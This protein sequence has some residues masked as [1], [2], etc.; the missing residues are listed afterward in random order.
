MAA[1]TSSQSGDWDAVATWGGGGY[2]ASGDTATI[3]NTHTVT[4]TGDETVGDQPGSSSNVLTCVAGGHLVVNASCSLTVRGQAYFG[5]ASNVTFGAGSSLHFDTTS[6]VLYESQ[7]GI[8]NDTGKIVFNGTSANPCTI[9]N[10]GDGTAGI[11][12]HA[13]GTTLYGFEATYTNITDM[14]SATY[15]IRYRHGLFS[16]SYCIFDGCAAVVQ[17]G[18]TTAS[19]NFSI[20]NCTFKNGVGTYD[21]DIT[22]TTAITGGNVRNVTENSFLGDIR[23]IDARNYSFSG[24]YFGGEITHAPITYQPDLWE[25]DFCYV[26]GSYTPA[27]AVA[28]IKDT[29]RYNPVGDN[30]HFLGLNTGANQVVDGA[31]FYGCTYV[32]NE[33]DGPLIGANPAAVRTYAL[34]NI[35]VLPSFDGT[36]ASC[37]LF[38]DNNNWASDTNAI[39]QVEHC[40]V[41]T[42]GR[43]GA[44]VAVHNGDD[45]AQAGQIAYIKNCIFWTVSGASDDAAVSDDYPVSSPPDDLITYCGNNIRSDNTDVVYDVQANA[46]AGTPGDGDFVVNPRFIDYN[47]NLATWASE[48]LGESGTDDELRTAAVAALEAR[49]DSGDPNYHAGVTIASL[50]NWIRH[51]F[52]PQTHV[53]MH[54]GDGNTYIGA[55]QPTVVEAVRGSSNC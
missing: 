31:I 19:A 45:R 24:N 5:G 28:T 18:S 34:H 37:T 35:L 29:F 27:L 51:G 7:M 12:L 49:N 22:C 13:S 26:D 9:D 2:P 53:A 33:C 8:G 6:G 39:Y 25:Y 44:Y 21:F 23:I 30:A 52:V 4:V 10:I 36:T 38:T 55:V 32:T 3:A 47:R 1:Y 20:T 43:G 46:F 17:S 40:T 50:H 54:G 14:D 42:G 48:V 41:F 11:D 16:V 15:S